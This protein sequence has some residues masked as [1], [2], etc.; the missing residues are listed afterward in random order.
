MKI[1]SQKIDTISTNVQVT[2][3][4][5]AIKQAYSSFAF[6]QRPAALL[7]FTVKEPKGKHGNWLV[8]DA[9]LIYKSNLLLRWL[10]T[11]LFGRKFQKRGLG[12]SGFG[13]VE[14]QSNHQP[15]IHLAITS[16]MPPK[17]LLKLKKVLFEK[18]KKID[19]FE[20]AGIDLQMIGSSDADFWRVGGYIAKDGNMLTLDIDGLA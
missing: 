4:R 15:H 2:F 11:G 6:Q 17:R 16:H 7:T 3:S 13:S 1:K 19:L 12:L 20:Q 18:I 10:N 5:Q 9:S 14:K 8:S